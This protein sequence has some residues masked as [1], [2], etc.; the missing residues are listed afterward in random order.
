MRPNR[1]IIIIVL[2]LLPVLSVSATMTQIPAGGEVFLGEE[3]LDISSA[4]WFPYDS[5]AYYPPGSSPGRDVP[6]DIRKVETRGFAASPSLYGERLGTWYQ[7]DNRRGIAGTVAFTIREPRATIRIID[8]NTL[9]ELGDGVVARGTGLL[10]QLDSNLASVARRPGYNPAIDG[11]IDILIISPGG[12]TLSAVV[13]RSGG[14]VSMT[15]MTSW[16]SLQTLPSPD[17][18]GWDTGASD[19]G[20]STLYATGKYLITPRLSFNRIDD[21]LRNAGREGYLR[22]TS[23]TI[24]GDRATISGERTVVRG[25]SFPVTITGSPGVPI[26]IWVDSGTKSGIPGDQPPMILFAQEGVNQDS[27][28]GPFQI[29]SYRPSSEGRRNLRDLVPSEPYQGVKYYAMVIPD[30]DGKRTIEFRTSD[31]T[32]DTRYSIRI[33]RAGTGGQNRNDEIPVTVVKG[34][35]SVV[36]GQEG[37]ALGDDVRL[38]GRNTESCTTYLFLTGPNLPSGGGRLDRPREA[39]RDGDPGSFTVADGD[40][41]SWDY[42]FNSGDLGVD[43]GVYT[44]YA[45][46]SPRDRLNLGSSPYEMIPITFK[47]PSVTLKRQETTVA[48]GD[49]LTLTGVSTGAS[50]S[51]VAV[52]I[53]GKNYF[54]YDRSSVE[55]GGLFEYELTG[56]ETSSLVAGQYFVIVQHPMGNGAFDLFPDGQRQLVLGMY[57]YMG[58]PIF[59]I[60]G[61]G[62]L[63][64]PE[65]ANALISALSSSFIDDTYT[66][67]EI[68]V[69]SPRIDI[70]PSSFIQQVGSP[71]YISGTTNLAPGNRL[72]VE[73]TDNRFA[74]TRKGDYTST[75]GF[76][77]FAEIRSSV[78]GS[79]IFNLTIPDNRLVPGEYRITIESVESPATVSGLLVVTL[80]A[81]VVAQPPILDQNVNRTVITNVTPAL[82]A[83]QT[84]AEPSITIT[85][86]PTIVPVT[87]EMVPQVTSTTGQVTPVTDDRLLLILAGIGVGLL[88]ALLTTVLVFLVTRK[89]KE[90]GGSNPENVESDINLGEYEEGFTEEEPDND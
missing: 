37:Y 40:C 88:I 74:P 34:S 42:Q 72:M 48:R 19:S 49:S 81:P 82:T 10:F 71:I 11:I 1:A 7:W 86:T 68:M 78:N 41:E 38:S 66:S 65:A 12:G 54:R 44:V 87:Q 21:N 29:G 16:N 50:G 76:S 4:V 13:T 85:S 9:Q 57:P 20:G 77:G 15:R 33:E 52:W 5:I 79:Q 25:N 46:P 55:R 24:G 31:Q 90:S 69:V 8:R 83:T 61:P 23:I 67:W 2:L 6:L 32:D 63:Q 26:Y 58:A 51:G 62:S 27:P 80:P 70:N 60:A 36:A 75:S 84:T 22:G 3:G 47:R 39:V 53:F 73:V 14:Q 18:G 89:R 56:A 30:R 35:V 43:P 17:T 64:G 45:V 28:D 59:R